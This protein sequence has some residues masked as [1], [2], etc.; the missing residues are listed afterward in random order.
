VAKFDPSGRPIFARAFGDAATQYPSAVSL[1]AQGN[2]FVVGN[3]QSSIDFGGP[4]GV[5]ATGA[6]LSTVYSENPYNVFVVELDASGHTVWSES[7]GDSAKGA[8]AAG[9]SVDPGGDLVLSGYFGGTIQFGKTATPLVAQGVF[10]PQGKQYRQ[11][12]GDAFVAKLTSAGGYRWSRSFGYLGSSQLPESQT[13]DPEGNIF[14]A[15]SFQG[16][17]GLRAADGGAAPIVST[18]SCAPGYFIFDGF[19]VKLDADGNLIWGHALVGDDSSFVTNIALDPA[20]DVIAT[21]NFNGSLDI[22]GDAGTVPTDAGVL[23]PGVEGGVACTDVFGSRPWNTFVAK[24]DDAGS[25][26][27]GFA[28]GEISSLGATDGNPVAVDRAGNI[29]VSGAVQNTGFLPAEDGGTFTLGG[30]DYFDGWLARLN[31][32][33]KAVWAASMGQPETS[34]WPQAIALGRCNSELYLGVIFALSMSV[35]IQDGGVR[36]LDAGGSS[37][38]PTWELALARFA[39]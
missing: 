26:Q 38:V 25:P 11:F 16:T 5:H 15:G 23:P 14:I 8:T 9:I 39:R 32:Q 31:P 19:L 33:G 2:I 24:F 3:F 13:V 29:F 20:G 17:L 28:L 18:A 10:Y 1:D 4:S 22:V 12:A 30:Y 37:G 35:P 21:G 27:W 6:P 36:V 7:F 34:S